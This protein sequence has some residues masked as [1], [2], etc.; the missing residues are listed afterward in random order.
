M[1]KIIHLLYS[2]QKLCEDMM[3]IVLYFLIWIIDFKM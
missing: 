3:V 1:G 2:K